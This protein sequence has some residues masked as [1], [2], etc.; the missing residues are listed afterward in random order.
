MKIGSK[1]IGSKN[2]CFIIAEMSANHSGKFSKAK[3]IIIKAKEA[4]ADAVKIQTYK[5]ET[6]T[7][8]SSKQ[9]FMINKKSPWAQYDSL[10]KLYKNTY[11]PWEWQSELFQIAKENNIIMF[12]SPFDD[13]SVD[14]LE[15]LNTLLIKLHLLKL[16]I[17]LCLGKLL[18]QKNLFYYQPD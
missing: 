3:E 9:D 17:Y 6:I 15:N 13:S 14:F 7:I 12:S 4:G 11:T 5:A 8:R 18:P 16:M 2:Q 10:F 1:N